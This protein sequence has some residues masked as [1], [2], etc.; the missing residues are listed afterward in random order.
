[1]EQRGHFDAAAFFA[2][3]DAQ[4]QGR[5]L[6][7]KQVADESQI[8]ASTLTRMGQGRRP[9]VDSLAALSQWAGLDAG[10]FVRGEKRG[11]AEPL[12]M[13]STYLRSDPNLTPEG[14]E[15]LEAVIQATYE[16]LRQHGGAS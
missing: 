4:R 11:T 2:A 10:D 1:M 14:A 9:D 13:I 12:A 5:G 3:L 15:A 7:W 6:T 16:R 8:S